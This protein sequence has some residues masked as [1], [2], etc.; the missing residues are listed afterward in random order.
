M[1]QGYINK[2]KLSILYYCVVSCL[3]IDPSKSKRPAPIPTP[4]RSPPTKSAT[5]T[6]I[7]RRNLLILTQSTFKDNYF[8]SNS[9]LIGLI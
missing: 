1:L 2:A 9:F 7:A 6:G 3:E 8:R 4:W 5:A